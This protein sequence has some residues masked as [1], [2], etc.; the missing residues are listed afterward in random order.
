M[1]GAEERDLGGEGAVHVSVAGPGGGC[2]VHVGVGQDQGAGGDLGRRKYG[3]NLGGSDR[4]NIRSISQGPGIGRA[5][6][7][8]RRHDG[9]L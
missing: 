5:L 9:V 6:R 2:M 3:G 8:A 4:T 7:A 1:P